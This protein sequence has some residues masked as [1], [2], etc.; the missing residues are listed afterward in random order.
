[1]F[2]DIFKEEIEKG[3][4]REDLYHRLGVILVHVP[5]LN[6]R[7]EDIPILAEYFL[8]KICEEHS[9][10]LKSISKEAI[11]ELQK[12]NRGLDR[13]CPSKTHLR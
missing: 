12:I 9:M 10:P 8:A 4:F 3:N 5:S 1:M 6:E 2:S 11:K 13:Q 7:I